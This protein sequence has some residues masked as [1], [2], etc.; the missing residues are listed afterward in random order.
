MARY[1]RSVFVSGVSAL[2]TLGAEPTRKSRKPTPQ[3]G[4]NNRPQ[5]NWY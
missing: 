2:F 1:T 5:S 4:V 3:R